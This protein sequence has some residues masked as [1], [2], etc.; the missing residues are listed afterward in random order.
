MIRMRWLPP[1]EA[2]EPIPTLTAAGINGDAHQPAS[3]EKRSDLTL[4][5]HKI[6]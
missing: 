4:I 6:C 1:V 3:A 5:S 2:N